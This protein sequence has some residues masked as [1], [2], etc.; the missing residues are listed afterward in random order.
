M[1]LKVDR[2]ACGVFV[3]SDPPVIDHGRCSWDVGQGWAEEPRA[4]VFPL[5][6]SKDFGMS[7]S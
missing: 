3:F 6:Y 4:A 7:F 5:R 1:F 2:F